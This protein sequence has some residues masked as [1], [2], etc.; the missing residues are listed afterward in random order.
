MDP[1][2]IEVVMAWGRSKMVLEIHNFS[3]ASRLL[4][5]VCKGFLKARNSSNSSHY[6]GDSIYMDRLL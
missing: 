4:S 3:G 5:E 2:K 1:S 6:E